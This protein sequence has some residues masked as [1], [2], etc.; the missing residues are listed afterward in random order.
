MIV[1]H[2]Y[3][4]M[5]ALFEG[6]VEMYNRFCSF[7]FARIKFPRKEIV[8][9]GREKRNQPSNQR[10]FCEQAYSGIS[11]KADRFITIERNII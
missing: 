10:S 2:S 5:F 8:Q 11:L 3:K 7:Y 9:Y 6:L 4:F 1:S